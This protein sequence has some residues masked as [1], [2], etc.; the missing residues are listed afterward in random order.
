[1]RT[2]RHIAVTLAFTLA[3]VAASAA[4]ALAHNIGGG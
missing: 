1:M 3:A 2:L 4:P